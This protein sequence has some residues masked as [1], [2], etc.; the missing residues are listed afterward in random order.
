MD[1]HTAEIEKKKKH[2]QPV[3]FRQENEWNSEI[4]TAFYRGF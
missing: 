2:A 3:L 4:G 1:Q